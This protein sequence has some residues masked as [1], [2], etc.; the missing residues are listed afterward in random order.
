MKHLIRFTVGL[1]L[2]TVPIGL[3]VMTEHP[4][5]FGIGIIPLLYLAGKGACT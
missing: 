5:A 2:L 4:Y 1:M 3:T